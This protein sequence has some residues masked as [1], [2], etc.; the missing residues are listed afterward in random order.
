MVSA[1]WPGSD[2]IGEREYRDVGLI[3]SA[4]AR[5]FQSVL[6]N[7]AYPTIPEKAAALFHSLNANHCFHNGNKRTAVLAFD[8]FLAANGHFGLLSNEAMHSLAE[9]TA[10]YKPRG[11]SH[12]ES[13]Q[14]ILTAVRDNIITL[15]SMRKE[16]KKTGGSLAELY[17]AVM[18]ARRTIRKSPYNTL[19]DP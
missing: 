3:D 13:Y 16:A 1:L 8:I 14:E 19:V 12:D 17:S 4:T 10:S 2:P 6:G 15:N 5:P 7:D 18:K 9:R 11:L